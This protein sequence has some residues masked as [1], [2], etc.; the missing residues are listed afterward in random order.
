MSCN[1]RPNVTPWVAWPAILLGLLTTPTRADV[2]WFDPVAGGRAPATFSGAAGCVP[3]LV[4][5]PDGTITFNDLTGDTARARPVCG[6]R[7]LHFIHTTV[8]RYA[9]Y[10]RVHPEGG[11]SSNTSRATMARTCPMVIACS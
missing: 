6:R 2:V 1:T 5:R 8:G 9:N 3:G 7:G 10:S 11:A 4:G